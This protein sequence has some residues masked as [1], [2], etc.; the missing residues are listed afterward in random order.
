MRPPAIETP[1]G[2]CQDEQDGV[3][4]RY[5]DDELV[6]VD[7][8]AG[9]VVHPT[10]RHGCGTLLDILRQQLPAPPS[11]VGR[12]DRMTSGV[13]LV[14]RNSVVHASLQRAIAAD[15]CVK[16]YIAFVHGR[17][18]KA[19]EIELRLRVDASDRRR[20]VAAADRGAPS[21]TIVRPVGT[22]TIAG[23]SLTMIRCQILTGRRHQIRAHL[24]AQGW[25]IVGDPI[26]GDP[27]S[28]T[29]IAALA[30]PGAVRRGQALHA[31][32][33]RLTQPF[34]GAIVDVESPPPPDLAPL[35][36]LVAS[37]DPS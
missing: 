29:A 33:L 4:I 32:R 20:V 6:V 26:Y 22:K 10:Y 37:T 23:Q 30:P 28:D 34:S 25:P 3:S 13:V 7:K 21:L 8:P 36:Q 15:N 24:A 27:S 1:T 9:L 2:T 19:C 14:A 5:A 12:L 16:E 11:I 35:V 18:V 31:S 17:V